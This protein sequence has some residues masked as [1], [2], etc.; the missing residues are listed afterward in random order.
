MHQEGALADIQRFF[1]GQQPLATGAAALYPW[2]D[3]IADKFTAKSRF[4]DEYKLW[5]RTVDQQGVLVPRNVCPTGVVDQRTDG[6][7]FPFKFHGAPR[8]DEQWRV[9]SETGNFLRAGL[10]GITQAPTGSGKTVL[11]AFAAAAVQ[12]RTLVIVTK[13]DLYDQWIDTAK[14]FLGLPRDMIGIVQQDVAQLNRPFVIAMMHTLALTDRFKAADFDGFG[15]VIWDEVHRLGADEFSNSAF[16]FNGKLRLGLSATPDRSDG[17]E[18][19][20]LAHI[21][22]VRVVS[23]AMQ[24]KPKVILVKT[25]W[26][27]PRV[28]RKDEYGNETYVKL[29]HSAGK[30]GHVLKHLIYW[31]SRNDIMADVIVAAAKKARRTVFF[32]D[33]LDHLAILRQE[34]VTRGVPGSDIAD[35]VGGLSAAERERAKKSP[36]IL[37]TYKMMGEGTDI[38]A[39]DTAVFGTPRSDIVQ[40]AGRVMRLFE[41][42]QQPTLVD[43]ID[44][45]SGVFAGYAE[46]RYRWYA[47][48]GADIVRV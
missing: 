8:N 20:F 32:S 45:D 23:S 14:Q 24:L 2:A 38:P 6:D 16:L 41:G 46:K 42:K 37:A 11:G 4:G 48:I 10:S 9:W 34:L 30:V 1:M 25:D 5:R 7:P 12:K 39:L 26:K 27:V 44:A 35:F 17:K 28:K 18:T 29:P 19:V 43:M 21:G 13:A 33:L 47:E 36:I 3:W 22:P 31:K 40:I 15:L